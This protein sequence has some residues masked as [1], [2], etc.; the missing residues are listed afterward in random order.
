MTRIH[1]RPR[2]PRVLSMEPHR[3]CRQSHGERLRIHGPVQP[4]APE[5][6][7]VRLTTL[8]ARAIALFVILYFAAQFTVSAWET[9]R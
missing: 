7:G 3:I 9:W 8:A 4:M 2:D 5:P 1:H 6:G